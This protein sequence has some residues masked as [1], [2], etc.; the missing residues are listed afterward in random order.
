MCDVYILDSN[1]TT[2]RIYS[3]ITCLQSFQ[4]FVEKLK[5][6]SLIANP[7]PKKSFK[8]HPTFFFFAFCSHLPLHCS[9]SGPVSPTSCWCYGPQVFA[10][11]LLMM[12]R[13]IL[14][15]FCSA[16][17]KLVP[18]GICIPQDY[19]RENYMSRLPRQDC[20]LGRKRKVN[21]Q[22]SHPKKKSDFRLWRWEEETTVLKCHFGV[23]VHFKR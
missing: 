4:R 1:Y 20:K 12:Q 21:W 13:Q 9:P 23:K 17:C 22:P 16:V 8:S 5:R 11:G 14:P 6:L 7:P 15:S 2:E 3:T 18:P 10:A 19:M